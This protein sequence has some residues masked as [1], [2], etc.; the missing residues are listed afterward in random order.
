MRVTFSI[1][2][3]WIVV[4]W[5][6]FDGKLQLLCSSFSDF[7]HDQTFF[8]CRGSYHFMTSAIDTMYFFSALWKSDDIH[9]HHKGNAPIIFHCLFN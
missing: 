6:W 2:T 3:Y 1:H 9:D 7:L 4:A 8:V 5:E